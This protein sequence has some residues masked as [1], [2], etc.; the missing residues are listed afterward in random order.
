[1]PRPRDATAS[2]SD[3]SWVRENNGVTHTKYA[4]RDGVNERSPQRQGV[5]GDSTVFTRYG[6][7][8][9]GRSL[10][11]RNGDLMPTEGNDLR[12]RH[13]YLKSPMHYQAIG[14]AQ[15]QYSYR[16]IP[17]PPPDP[18]QAGELEVLLGYPKWLPPGVESVFVTAETDDG[19]YDRSE[20]LH[21]R[22]G[23]AW[24]GPEGRFGGALVLTCT[25][26]TRVTLHLLAEYAGDHPDMPPRS[27]GGTTIALP[28]GQHDRTPAPQRRVTTLTAPLEMAV[29]LVWQRTDGTWQ[30]EG[31]AAPA[32]HSL[33]P[34]DTELHH[35]TIDMEDPEPY[36]A[37]VYEPYD[38]RYGASS[39]AFSPS[40]QRSPSPRPR[41][42]SARDRPLPRDRP[43]MYGY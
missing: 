22:G 14:R 19:A 36:G 15:R 31:H 32:A 43:L 13:R 42:H 21:L 10:L 27:I 12:P 3:R 30:S 26:A 18:H 11:E 41:P 40:K 35:W 39:R 37:P 25:R 7:H 4:C 5:R 24:S 17:P 29:Q 6:D 33:R 16:D 1:M 28:T 2:V 20:R 34:D 9:F 23:V 38:A 8:K